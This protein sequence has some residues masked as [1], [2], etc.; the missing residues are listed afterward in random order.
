M[1]ALGEPC[2]E[3]RILNVSPKPRSRKESRLT[4]IRHGGRTDLRTRMSNDTR[5]DA[6]NDLG[7]AQREE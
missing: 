5:F 1:E 7:A 2:N 6:A 3:A 4:T